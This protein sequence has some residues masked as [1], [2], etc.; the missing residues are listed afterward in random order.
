MYLKNLHSLKTKL[1]NNIYE[2]STSC[3]VD[4]SFKK[5]LFFCHSYSQPLPLQP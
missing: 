1:G 3:R 4:F 2:N 5:A